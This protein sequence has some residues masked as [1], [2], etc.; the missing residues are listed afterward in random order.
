MDINARN[1]C[2]LNTT[3][4]SKFEPGRTAQQCIFDQG[5]EVGALAKQMYPMVLRV[6]QG[7]TDFDDALCSTKQALKLRR[8]LLKHLLRPVA[9]TAV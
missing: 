3:T 1:S 9:V 8:P 2:G 4:R 6:G 5:H 7:I